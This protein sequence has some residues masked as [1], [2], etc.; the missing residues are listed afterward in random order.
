MIDFARAIQGGTHIQDLMDDDCELDGIVRRKANEIRLI[1][2]QI[3]DL[4]D[5]P[6]PEIHQGTMGG[7]AGYIASIPAGPHASDFQDE[8]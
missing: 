2:Y 3:C 1:V 8:T 4:V 6:Y 7:L 5:L